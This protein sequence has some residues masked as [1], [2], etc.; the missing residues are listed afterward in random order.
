MLT[1]VWP[2]VTVSPT[3]RPTRFR[4]PRMGAETWNTSLMRLVP[5]SSTVT[6]RLPVAMLVVSTPIGRGHRAQ[7]AAAA[8]ERTIHRVRRRLHIWLLPGFEHGDK[9]EAVN[10]AAD[11]QSEIGR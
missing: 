2:C 5:S 4:R 6:T 7:P 9:V 11:H 3:C 1:S 10:P 8:S